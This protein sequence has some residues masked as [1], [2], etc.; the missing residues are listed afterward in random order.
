MF[1]NLFNSQN[2]YRATTLTKRLPCILLITLGVGFG[3]L[4]PLY[5]YIYNP[6]RLLT[7]AVESWDTA[8]L[9]QAINRGVDVDSFVNG[10]RPIYG[11]L[12][13]KQHDFMQILADAGADVHLTQPS[14]GIN[15]A[16]LALHYADTTSLH[17]LGKAGAD[18]NTNADTFGHSLLSF[19][20]AKN[21]TSLL[22]TVL[23]YSNVNTRDARGTPPIHYA[24]DTD[25]SLAT[26]LITAGADV[27]A[28][29]NN[30]NTAVHKIQQPRTLALLTSHGADVNTLNAC[31]VPPMAYH[32]AEGNYATYNHL[33]T[34]GAA[35]DFEDSFGNNILF[36]AAM[37][38]ENKLAPYIEKTFKERH[39][40]K[41]E[42]CKASL[43]T[44]AIGVAVTALASTKLAKKAAERIF[45]TFCKRKGLKRAGGMI[46]PVI[47]AA[48][49]IFTLRRTVREAKELWSIYKAEKK[50]EQHLKKELKSIRQQMREQHLQCVSL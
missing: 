36:Y 26:V 13:S 8:T 32:V 37:D 22:P 5:T 17:I 33:L 50:R 20:V 14:T 4:R 34:S 15:L 29:D 18:F 42:T 44:S 16:G 45:W 39:P 10:M 1:T 12:K 46:V 28:T 49:T 27:N 23:R 24:T 9:Q 25:G 48:Y 2:N 19:A 47:G 30:G 21:L 7:Q 40:E 6:Y 11:A 38:A 35:I 31:G 41:W 3:I 43:T